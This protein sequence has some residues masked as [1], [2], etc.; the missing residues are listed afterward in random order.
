MDVPF[1]DAP[2]SIRDV[3]RR[4]VTGGNPTAGAPYTYAWQVHLNRY[5]TPE[6]RSWLRANGFH[7]SG[8]RWYRAI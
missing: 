8:Q 5:S 4:V 1:P 2:A 3:V 6:E 7:A